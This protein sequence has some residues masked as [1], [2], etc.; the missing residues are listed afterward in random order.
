MLRFFSGMRNDLLNTGRLRKYLTY[1]LGE[2][3]LVMIG[4]LLAMQVNNWNEARKNK[5]AELKALND[6]RKEFASNQATFQEHLH[7]KKEKE[8]LW[9]EFIHKLSD[10]NVPEAA[11]PKRRIDPGSITWNP[12]F[13]MLNSLLHSGN[14]DHLENDSLKVALTNWEGILEDFMEDERIHLDFTRDRLSTYPVPR[15]LLE[16]EGTKRTPHFLFQDEE[17]LDQLFQQAFRDINFQNLMIENLYWLNS[18]IE[19][20][21]PLHESFNLILRHLDTEIKK[22]ENR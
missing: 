7:Y 13:G 9:N 22:L 20:S 14:I 18:T 19:E 17:E 11:K 2:I 8:Q 3:I 1:A 5:T 15:P 6:L 12:S 16:I 10:K 4:I 21:A